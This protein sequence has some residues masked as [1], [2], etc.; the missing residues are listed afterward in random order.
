MSGQQIT[1]ALFDVGNVI[2][3]A[4]HEITVAILRDYGIPFSAAVQFYVND[5][6]PNFARG[7]ITGEEFG[8]RTRRRI[9]GLSVEQIRR[10]HDA[11]M[12][13]VDEGT[14]AILDALRDRGITIAFATDTNEWQT[15]R[16]RELVNLAA[17]GRVFR[18]HD[19]GA[20]K[21]DGS[22]FERIVAELGESPEHILFVDD[23]SEKIAMAA[24]L[25]MPTHWFRSGPLGAASLHSELTARGLLKREGS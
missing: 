17:Y 11:H 19:L 15:A 7:K 10:A 23:S 3:R 2:V 8:K 21:A 13:D 1:V 18:S 4:T 25:R 5:D 14:I 6:Y 16:E 9:G 20:L 24:A 22:V 12:Y